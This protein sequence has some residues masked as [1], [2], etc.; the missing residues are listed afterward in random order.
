[1]RFILLVALC[2]RVAAK[3]LLEEGSAAASQAVSAVARA[4]IHVLATVESP[5]GVQLQLVADRA[6]FS[7]RYTVGRRLEDALAGDS[8]PSMHDRALGNIE[9]DVWM[10]ALER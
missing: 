4:K 10:K 5:P 1:M 9:V 6:E 2:W 3:R 8:Q 7:Q